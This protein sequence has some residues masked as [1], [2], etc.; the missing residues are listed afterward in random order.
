MTD[1]ISALTSLLTLR[2]SCRTCWKDSTSSQSSVCGRCSCGVSRHCS[3]TLVS[4]RTPFCTHIAIA[5]RTPCRTCRIGVGEQQPLHW[6]PPRSKRQDS[7]PR[8]RQGTALLAY[9]TPPRCWTASN[10]NRSCSTDDVPFPIREICLKDESSSSIRY[11]ALSGESL[12]LSPGSPSPASPP[13]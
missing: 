13:C 3:D 6:R 4:T 5:S 2:S 9:R 11:H 10:Q 1:T 7:D 12:P 8:G